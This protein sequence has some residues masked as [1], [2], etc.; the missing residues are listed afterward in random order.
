MKNQKG[1]GL[2]GVMVVVGVMSVIA[3]GLAQFTLQAMLVS[4]TAEAKANLTSLVQSMSGEAFN[5]TT[6]TAAVTQNLQ[7]YGPTLQFDILKNG[8][9]LP[10]YNL[11]VQNVTY[12]NPQLIATGYDG[13]T[14]Y[15]GLITLT[16]TS[17]RQILGSQTF[18]PRPI[19][20]VYLTV[21][22]AGVIT[23][24]GPSL[25]TLPTAPVQVPTPPTVDPEISQA[26]TEIGGNM[27]GNVCSFPQA[28]A[29]NNDPCNR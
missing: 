25:P 24:C 10:I 20:Q 14:V 19:A 3:L 7:N 29:G 6:C 16:A 22:P 17:T 4:Q 28:T 23:Q 15:Y 13:T 18:A 2:I 8:A 21:S 26:C 12:T 1:F 9:I 11:A 27:V 5:Q